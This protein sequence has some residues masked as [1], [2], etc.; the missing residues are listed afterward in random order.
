MTKSLIHLT[1]F[2]HITRNTTDQ[3]DET[4]TKR[5]SKVK[6]RSLKVKQTQKRL[7]SQDEL[8]L[9][10]GIS[11]RLHSHTLQYSRYSMFRLVQI[12]RKAAS[13]TD[14]FFFQPRR[15]TLYHYMYQLNKTQKKYIER[16]SSCP[17]RCDLKNDCFYKWRNDFTF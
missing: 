17:N 4:Q 1:H 9:I 14:K 16:S 8:Q 7:L 6:A 11:I 3:R 2:T 12:R 5:A 15:V 10:S 13:L